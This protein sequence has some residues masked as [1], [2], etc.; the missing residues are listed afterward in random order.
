MSTRLEVD[1]SK[2]FSG[3]PE[4]FQGVSTGTFTYSSFPS[5]WKDVAS[6]DPATTS[7][8][9]S[10]VVIKTQDAH[11]ES[12]KALATFPA[13]ALSQGIYRDISPTNYYNSQA[14]VRIDQFGQTDPTVNVPDPEKPGFLLCGC[15]IGTEEV[16]DVPMAVGFLAL[17]G[18]IDPG[19]A[20]F[21][22]LMA[23]AETH[24]WHL[25]AGTQNV[26]ADLN[27][28][29]TI[30]E[31][32]WYRAQTDFDADKGVLHG[33][34]S[35]ISSGAILADKMLFLKDPKYG[36]YDPTV[37][38]KLNA[39]AFFDGEH[40][41]ANSHDPSLTQPALA[42]VDNIDP[43]KYSA[44]PVD[45]GHSM[46]GHVPTPYDDRSHMIAMMS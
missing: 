22:G 9:P 35:D 44:M 30:Q 7:P 6:V 5:G 40:T 23:S 17:D 16:A 26:I 15:P 43:A 37:D 4:T 39:E 8:K 19:D 29:V 45:G 24:T 31:G 33:V 27:M 32:H 25:V 46:H 11:G 10:A 41:L 34:V 21:V 14:D 13:V 42:V 1:S 12:T 28:G 18:K 36:A 20:P 3:S 2:S 38:G